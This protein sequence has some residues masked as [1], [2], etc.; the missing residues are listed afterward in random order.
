[1]QR[2]PFAYAT[3]LRLRASG[4]P[5]VLIANAL[6]IE[7]DGLPLLL[8]LAD[9]KLRRLHGL[10]APH[11]PA[12]DA[13]PDAVASEVTGHPPLRPQQPDVTAATAGAGNSTEEP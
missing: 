10:T 13:N 2:L 1:M 7:P 4:A 9:A 8:E 12:P 6:G 5:D 3:A 11:A